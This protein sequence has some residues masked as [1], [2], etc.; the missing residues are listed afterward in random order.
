MKRLL[1]VAQ[2]G[3]TLAVLLAVLRHVDARAAANALAHASPAW[4]LLALA[5]NVVAVCAST[6][7]WRSL[8][9]GT[10]PPY[11]TLWRVYLV[12]M[13]YNNLGLGTVLGDAYRYAHLS[14]AGDNRP[15]AAV[16]VLGER[17]VSG[18]VLVA[19]AAF[20]SLYF[21]TSRPLL[22]GAIWLSLVLGAVLAAIGWRCAPVFS[23]LFR[24]PTLLA[25]PLAS[26]RHAVG[27]L[28]ARPRAVASA[29]GWAC[30]VQM[31]TVV[32]ALFVLRS[33]GVSPGPLAVF[34][35]VPLI[36]LAVLA[37]VSI[38]GIG[39][40]EVTYLTLFGY[41]G[42]SHDQAL[43]AALLSYVT[44]LALTMLGGVFALVAL[45]PPVARHPAEP[46]DSSAA[47]A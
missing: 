20:G 27:A 46:V 45:R 6:A 15:A 37:P 30:C 44:T 32:A 18:C 40:R 17:I 1:P 41:V 8:M 25:S 22:S 24:L 39:V 38:Q 9:P 42:V 33:L 2:V 23:R 47:A 43:A 14:R 21:A 29:I 31:C 3:V 19:F 12:G 7:L 36:A 35:V 34:A 10:R 16:S 26:M 11:R 13:F 4:V 5:M 28:A